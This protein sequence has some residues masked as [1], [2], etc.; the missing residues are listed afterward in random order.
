MALSLLANDWRVSLAALLPA[1]ALGEVWRAPTSLLVRDGG[2]RGAPGAS[3]A[4]HL[5]C[6]NALAGLGPLSAAALARDGDLRHALLITPAAF[7]LAAGLFW[8]AEGAL[9]EQ[10]EQQRAAS[11]GGAASGS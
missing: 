8:M 5:A 2:P 7:A 11:S 9:Q 6:R 3:T 4:A 1:L 10:K